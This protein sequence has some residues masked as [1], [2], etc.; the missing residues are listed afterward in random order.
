MVLFLFIQNVSL[1]ALGEE[2]RQWISIKNEMEDVAKRVYRAVINSN[3][4]ASGNVESN[5]GL[6]IGNYDREKDYGYIFYF[7][8]EYS[9]VN[10]GFY[11]AMELLYDEPKPSFDNNVYSMAWDYLGQFEFFESASFVHDIKNN[12]SGI[13][14]QFNKRS[15]GF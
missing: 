3:S 2:Y 8:S 15:L 10:I 9:S 5:D 6:I 14:L 12:F 13:L 1:F 4:A 7:C 11:E